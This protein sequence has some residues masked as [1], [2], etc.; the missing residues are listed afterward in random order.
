MPRLAPDDL[1]AT[2]AEMGGWLRISLPLINRRKP[3]LPRTLELRP[4]FRPAQGGMRTPEDQL[5]VDHIRQA[6]R[7][8][9]LGGGGEPAAA[10]RAVLINLSLA[11]ETRPF[12]RITSPIASA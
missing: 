9:E 4:V 7:R 2:L 6:V 5:L 12:A 8:I 1:S 10:P 3:P 11:D